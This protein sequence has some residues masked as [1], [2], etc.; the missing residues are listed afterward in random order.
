MRTSFQNSG[1]LYK[2]HSD[3]NTIVAIARIVARHY[4]FTVVEPQQAEYI[5]EIH[6]AL[7]DGGACVSG[8]EAAEL[9]ASYTISILTLGAFPAT[10]VHCLV[11]DASLYSQ[12]WW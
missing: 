1:R 2:L 3:A 10:A 11:V 9:D 4:G 6:S 5:I 8:V 12:F 7:P